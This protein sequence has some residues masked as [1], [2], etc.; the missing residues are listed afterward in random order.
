MKQFVCIRGPRGCRV[1]IDETTLETTG[2]SCPRGA[3]YAKDELTNPTRTL[4]S[5]VIVEN[6]VIR[7]C[8]VK[9]D[10]P[11]PKPIVEDAAKALDGMKIEAPVRPGQILVEHFMGTEANL[12]ATRTIGKREDA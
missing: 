3:E 12:V 5:T 4:T 1:Q 10:R 2:N 9:T 11:I 8:P 6:A 7:R